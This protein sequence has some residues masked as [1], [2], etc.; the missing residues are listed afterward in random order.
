MKN[1]VW[2]QTG[3][4][5]HQED[6]IFVVRSQGNLLGSFSELDDAIQLCSEI[7]DSLHM[8]ENQ[9]RILGVD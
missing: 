3:L 6:A 5:V 7:K 4:E 9:S 1:I 2:N 8:K